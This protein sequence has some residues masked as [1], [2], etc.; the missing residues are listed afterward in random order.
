MG[1]PGDPDFAAEDRVGLV[2]KNSTTGETKVGN[3]TAW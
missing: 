1:K 2:T 3:I